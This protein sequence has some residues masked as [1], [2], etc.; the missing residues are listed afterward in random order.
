MGNFVKIF[1]YFLFSSAKLVNN[2]NSLIENLKGP[3]VNNNDSDQESR[4][5]RSQSQVTDNSQITGTNDPA[6]Y[7]PKVN[8]KHK[9][10]IKRAGKSSVSQSMSEIEKDKLDDHVVEVSS[11]NLDRLIGGWIEA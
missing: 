7:E 11:E 6:I 4:S 8:V 9:T 10:R 5:S 1:K 3:L 2:F